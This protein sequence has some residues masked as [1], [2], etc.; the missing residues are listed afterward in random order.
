VCVCVCTNGLILFGVSPNSMFVQLL[1]LCVYCDKQH[2]LRNA[3]EC[4]DYFSVHIRIMQKVMSS[5]FP[6]DLEYKPSH[7]IWLFHYL[8]LPLSL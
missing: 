8:N 5:K 3:N 6:S 4:L 2:C 7:T 1:F